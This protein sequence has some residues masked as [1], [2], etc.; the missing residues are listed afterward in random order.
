VLF[1][2]LWLI[3]RRSSQTDFPLLPSLPRDADDNQGLNGADSRPNPVLLAS[4]VFHPILWLWAA[5]QDYNFDIKWLN[6]DQINTV[7]FGYET[8][9]RVSCALAHA[10]RGDPLV[11]RS[12]TLPTIVVSMSSYSILI[13]CKLRNS[14]PIPLLSSATSPSGL[15]FLSPRRTIM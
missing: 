7:H 14:D 4:S 5:G 11:F 8:A 9:L 15:T 10:V 1:P 3:L 2:F 12:I 13:V 6:P